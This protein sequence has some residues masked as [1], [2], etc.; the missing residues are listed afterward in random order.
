VIAKYVTFA[1]ISILTLMAAFILF[2]DFLGNLSSITQ[3]LRPKLE[4]SVAQKSTETVTHTQEQN[5]AQGGGSHATSQAHQLGDSGKLKSAIQEARDLQHFNFVNENNLDKMALLLRNESPDNIAIA[6][7]YLHPKDVST[8]LSTMK[9]QTRVEVTNKLLHTLEATPDAVKDIE[10][11]LSEKVDYLLGGSDFVLSVLDLSDNKTRERLIADIAT[12][13]IEASERLRSEMFLFKDIINLT[14]NE[15][16]RILERMD[17]ETL[18]VALRD[19]TPELIDKILNTMSPG[20]KTT[21]RQIMDLMQPQPVKKVN[22]AQNL[23]VKIIR[24][25]INDGLIM[26]R[27]VKKVDAYTVEVEQRD[28]NRTI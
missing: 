13:D 23:T 20:G 14:D 6:L 4:V 5:T 27:V 25:L 7:S 26:K 9:P 21:V 22:E 10:K 1:A 12:H 28:D 18:S 15:I 19:A 8:I 2:R 11:R 3:A 17:N 24:Q 16:R